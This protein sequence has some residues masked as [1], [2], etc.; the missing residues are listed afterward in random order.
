MAEKGLQRDKTNAPTSRTEEEYRKNVQYT[1]QQ[2]FIE[3]RKSDTGRDLRD[4]KSRYQGSR[5]T[6]NSTNKRKKFLKYVKNNKKNLH[7]SKKSTTFAANS[8]ISDIFSNIIVSMENSKSDRN[9]TLIF[10]IHI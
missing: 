6:K 1:G 10:Y 3:T 5:Y 9:V 4:E 8:V 2:L 7:I